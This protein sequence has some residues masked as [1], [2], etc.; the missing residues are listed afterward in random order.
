M[1]PKCSKT[2]PEHTSNRYKT[3]SGKFQNFR[4]FRC[5]IR[6]PTT[7]QKSLAPSSI[8]Q[9]YVG[10]LEWTRMLLTPSHRILKITIW[11]RQLPARLEQGGK[12][13]KKASKSN[14]FG[15]FSAVAFDGGLRSTLLFRRSI[16]LMFWHLLAKQ[17]IPDGFYRFSCENIACSRNFYPPN[18]DQLLIDGW[19]FT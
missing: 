9:R 15:A 8:F 3:T 14:Y 19:I 5:Q 2:L 4:F 1:S 7:L 10:D 11:A 17:S 18:W 6:W 12:T 16:E 13:S